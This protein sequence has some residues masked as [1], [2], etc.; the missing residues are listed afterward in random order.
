MKKYIKDVLFKIANQKNI[1]LS[2]ISDV[3]K[4]L[5]NLVKITNIETRIKHLKDLLKKYPD[6]PNI[7][8]N[9]ALSLH[10]LCSTDKFYYFNVYGVKRKQWL[11]ENNLEELNIDIIWQGMFT[12]SLGNVYPVE[13]LINAQNFDLKEKKC[14]YTFLGNNKPRN[15]TLFAFFK[16]HLKIVNNV[17]IIRNFE[18]LNNYLMLPLGLCL[19]MDNQ[20][21]YLDFASNLTQQAKINSKHNKPF[22][23]RD[24]EY[25]IPGY[26]ILNEMGINKDDWF[27]TI[28]MREPSY[29]G[30]TKDNTTQDFRNV[31]IDDYKDSIREIIKMG[32]NVIR[33]GDSN[34]TKI[35]NFKGFFDYANSK[36]KSE[37]MDVFFWSKIKIL[38][39]YIIRLLSYSNAFW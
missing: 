26:K 25:L 33:V 4:H 23:D 2:R 8:Y 15:K 17:E 37:F 24:D 1:K 20:T 21:P 36:Y 29:R 16:K 6:Y 10:Y 38:Y 9:L 34:M 19:P 32:G 3:E 39:W 12:G 11:I 13:S 30:E 35:E 27:V 18:S 28:H 22:L 5:N 14:L 31:N 7:Y